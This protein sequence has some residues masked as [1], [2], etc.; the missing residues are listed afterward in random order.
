VFNSLDIALFNFINSF[1]RFQFLDIIMPFLSETLFL[2]LAL[3]V[4]LIGYIFYCQH[5]YGEALWRVVVLLILFVLSF[6]MAYLIS[7]AFRGSSDKLSPYQ[8]IEGSHHYDTKTRE[9]HIVTGGD[10]SFLFESEQ[11]ID[12]MPEQMI[13]SMPEQ[14]IELMP[15]Q[16]IESMP[17]EMPEQVLLEE[18]QMPFADLDAEQEIE[19]RQI[20]EETVQDSEQSSLEQISSGQTSLIQKSPGQMSSIPSTLSAVAMVVALILA[21]LFPKINSVIFIL[22]FV[23]GWS[24]IYLGNHYPFDVVMGWMI[25]IFSVLIVWLLCELFFRILAP[26]KKL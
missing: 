1:V 2:G 11:I 20:T 4:F 19:L 7:D 6:F 23:I 22:P 5:R 8:M 25:G 14:M 10:K 17:E 3:L 16:M 13:E 21:L 15:E 12:E 26:Q 24:T 9:W 18:F